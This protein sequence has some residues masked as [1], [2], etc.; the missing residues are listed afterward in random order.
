[1]TRPIVCSIGTTDPWN[2]A[3]LGLDQRTLWECG[4]RPVSVVTSVS[5]QDK[6]GLHAVAAV[7]PDLIFAQWQSL[8]EAPVAAVRIGA[9]TGAVTVEAIAAIVS[10][11]TVPVVYDPV[12]R[13]TAGGSFADDATIDAIRTRLLEKVS[14]CTPNLEEAERL[15]GIRVNSTDQMESAGRSLLSTGVR[16]VLVTGGH[17]VGDPVDVLVDGANVTTFS[18]PRIG[19]TMRGSGCVL[20]AALAAFLARQRPL[21]DAIEQARAY[22]RD[23]IGSAQSLGDMYLAR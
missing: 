7:D 22:V 1:V 2:A 10:R 13:P 20:A 4:A 15:T 17:R 6:R 19:L 3:G 9:L 8:R 23:K 18:A 12:L 14:I 21:R 5:A 16:A 11:V